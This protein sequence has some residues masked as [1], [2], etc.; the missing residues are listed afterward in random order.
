MNKK[1][2]A[3]IIKLAITIL[4]TIAATLGLQACC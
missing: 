2:W 1:T 4:S 3:E